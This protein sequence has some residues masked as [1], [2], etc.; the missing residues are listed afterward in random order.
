VTYGAI[1]HD[2]ADQ[3]DG[4]AYYYISFIMKDYLQVLRVAR[5]T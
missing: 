5:E 1:H 4:L 3:D 2:V